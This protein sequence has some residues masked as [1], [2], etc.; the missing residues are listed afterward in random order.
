MRRGAGPWEA[1]SH[2]GRPGTVRNLRVEKSSRTGPGEEARGCCLGT[3]PQAPLPA[4]NRSNRNLASCECREKPS[5][6]LRRH[7]CSMWPPRRMR[8]LLRR[9][10]SCR[11]F[12]RRLQDTST[13]GE[14]AMCTR[15]WRVRCLQRPADPGARGPGSTCRWGLSFLISEEDSLIYAIPGQD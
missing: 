3:L 4:P 11:R 7:H 10:S 5:R 14:E 6:S 2:T 12:S 8:H 1:T 15:G 13:A 9:A